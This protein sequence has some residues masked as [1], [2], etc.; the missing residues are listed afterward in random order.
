MREWV[1]ISAAYLPD[2][3]EPFGLSTLDDFLQQELLSVQ[4]EDFLSM[5]HELQ[6]AFFSMVGALLSAAWDANAKAARTRAS[7]NFFIDFLFSEFRDQTRRIPGMFK[8]FH[9]RVPLRTA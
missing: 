6:S 7:A 4:E 2:C 8:A 1:K 9:S 3:W 5:Q